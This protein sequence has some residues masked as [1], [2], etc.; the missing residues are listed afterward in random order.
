M[1]IRRRHLTG[2]LALCTLAGSAGAQTQPQAC[3]KPVYLAFDTGSMAVAPLVAVV[4]QR[5]QVRATFFASAATTAS[6]DA[7]DTNWAPWWKARGAEGH[8][9]ASRTRDEV[10]WLGDERGVQPQFR[11]RPA[12]GAFAGR[13]FT[14]SAAKYCENIAQAADRVGYVTGT[15]PLPLFR[16]PGGRTSPKLLAA[17][18]GCG[19]LHVD[20]VPV[21]FLSS[22]AAGAKGPDDQQIAQAVARVR[23]GDVLAAHLGVWSREV[24]Q[25]PV[26]LE[27][28]ITGLKAQGFCFR[29]LRDHPAYR[30]WV[31][32]RP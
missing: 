26:G 16:A 22:A 27:P 32:A 1:R 18:Q 19:Y 31:A 12:L 9:F 30:D 17:A 6:G 25:V 28:L 2:L 11:V 4:L 20:A 14:W 21:G 29:T 7:L 24:P 3:D 10:A 23:P 8:A 5:Q 13:T 15:R